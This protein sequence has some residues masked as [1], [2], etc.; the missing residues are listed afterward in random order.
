MIKFCLEF[1]FI[2][3]HI[4]WSSDPLLDNNLVGQQKWVDSITVNLH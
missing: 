3:N 1:I 2:S 4:D